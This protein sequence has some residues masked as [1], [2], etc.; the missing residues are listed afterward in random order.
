MTR[1][2]ACLHR[3]ERSAYQIGFESPKDAQN[4]VDDFGGA[5]TLHSQTNYGRPTTSVRSPYDG[6]LSAREL[7]DLLIGGF[8]HPDF[9]DMHTFVSEAA[10]AA[11]GVSRKSL[12][13]DQAHGQAGQ[14]AL[15]SVALS[16]RLAAANDSAC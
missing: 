2:L 9:P 10:Q 13:E 6:I 11:G 14:A 4:Q 1:C 16:S 12:I 8:P 3:N 15:L 7:E 5:Q